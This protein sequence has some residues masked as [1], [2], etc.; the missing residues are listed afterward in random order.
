VAI[1][2]GEGSNWAP[3]WS[4]DGR[5][6]ACEVC[7]RERDSVFHIRS[8][9]TNQVREIA[10][11][12]RHFISHSLHWSP[13]GKALLG[14][15]QNEEWER[16]V[17]RI[18]VQSGSVTTLVGKDRGAPKSFPLDPILASDGKTA[19]YTRVGSTFPYEGQRICRRDLATGAEQELY[20]TPAKASCL[21]LS[22]DGQH[23]AFVERRALKLISVSGGDPRE[24]WKG[25]DYISTIAWTPDGSHLLFQEGI[26]Q[27]SMWFLSV[28]EGKVERLDVDLPRL[29]H[30]RIHP[31]GRQI[32][33]TAR[34]E[35][36]RIELWALEN[37]LLPLSEA[38]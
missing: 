29:E 18:D 1:E 22:P 20:A 11:N 31:D 27:P 8:V 37:F 6:L 25:D 14:S 16:G 4:P 32:A 33:F 9:E 2:R 38:K 10:P 5:Y 7:R 19:F 12:I 21:A 17:L 13:D 35:P 30:L 34:L 23:L 24:M 36:D 28:A 26:A 15:G 3:A